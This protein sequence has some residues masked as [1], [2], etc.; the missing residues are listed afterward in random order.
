MYAQ[1]VPHRLREGLPPDVRL[2]DKT[3][4]GN[5]VDGRTSAWND[6]GLLTWPDGHTVIVAGF[7]M[8]STAAKE[9]RDAL[10]ADLARA[11]TAALGGGSGSRARSR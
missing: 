9:Q 3:G 5:S 7:L 8:N 11:V 4:S 10:F 2:A 1:T 6:I